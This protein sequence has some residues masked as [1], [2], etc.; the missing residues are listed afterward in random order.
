MSTA[1][2]PRPAERIARPRPKKRTARPHPT[3]LRAASEPALADFLALEVR[4]I[5]AAKWPVSPVVWWQPELAL[6][7]PQT[8]GLRNERK[9]KTPVAGFL[10]VD[11]APVCAAGAVVSPEPAVPQLP[12]RISGS[13]LAPIGWDP[14]TSLGEGRE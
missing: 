8:S 14:R 6:W 10:N 1:E 5:D 13:D 7:P 12:I 11:L 2:L 9:H 4:A 3:E